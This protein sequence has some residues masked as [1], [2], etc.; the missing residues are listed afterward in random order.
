MLETVREFSLERLTEHGEE[1]A[2]RRA[3]AAYYLGLAERLDYAPFLPTGPTVLLELDADQAN[4]RAAL[5]WLNENAPIEDAARLV[6][7]L[8]LYWLI[9][10]YLPGVMPW[11]E[12][13]MA[14]DDEVSP[15]VRVRTGIV[16]ALAM[17][18]RRD[19]ER[20]RSLCRESLT[21]AR[22]AGDRLG[23][24]QALTVLGVW[25]SSVGDYAQAATFLREAVAVAGTLEDRTQ[26]LGMASS[27]RSNL[28]VALR[29]L[30]RIDE[31]A[32]L[33]EEALAGQR[34]VGSV[35]GEVNAL[36]DLADV[37][38]EKGD[39][40]TALVRVREALRLAW[41]S[42]EQRAIAGMLEGGAC[43][44]AGLG[45]AERAAR[46]FAASARL[47]ESSG[48]GDWL[49]LNVEACERGIATARAQLGDEQFAVAW[50]A[51]RALPLADA[52]AEAL[53]PAAP[54]DDRGAV[55]RVA[56]TVRESEILDLL[57]AG[58]TDRE[59]AEALF[60]SVRTVEAH[61]SRLL[62]KL[63]VRTRTAAVG[64][65]IV[66]GLVEPD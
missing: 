56:I 45:W 29:G 55:G 43:A 26:S 35:R 14:R 30:G 63:G 10:G 53:D 7:S 31:A 64:A 51:G 22:E 17:L 54:P 27:A 44:A 46:I 25:A 52:V 48:I 32:V 33:H 3:H 34:A 38:L 47:R 50:A 4:M 8:G 39:L 41:M 16:L 66:A 9:R 40:E 49:P 11:I 58:K 5:A 57:V 21:L 59:I 20:V 13:V 62:A 36:G 1:E 6:G 2:V 23:A 60:I 61:V 65:A 37:A 42:G 12:R 24:A 18:A 28:G 15:A 19:L